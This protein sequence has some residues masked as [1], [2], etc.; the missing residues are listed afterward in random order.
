MERIHIVAATND[1]YA[2]HL[3]VMLTSLFENKKSK[4][5]VTIH[6]IDG[7]L[8][9]D[10]KRRLKNSVKRFQAEIRFLKVDKSLYEAVKVRY[11]LSKETYYRI[12][13]PALLGQ[14]INKAVY[15]DCDLI[16]KED[17]ANLWNISVHDFE[18]GAVQIPGHVDRYKELSI[19]E[20]MG[21][22]NAGVLLLNLRKWRA[23]HTSDKVL[24]YIRD[25]QKKL[26]Y[27]DQDALNAVLKGKW[28][29]LDRRWN[30]QVHRHRHQNFKP[31][32]IHYTAT[33]K[34]WSG[35]P[36]FKEEYVHY[37]RKTIW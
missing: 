34:P 10:K 30:Y 13:I 3:A 36:R 37:L 24:R 4:N 28:K 17:I 25:N 15:L 27:M 33:V 26:K 21:Y 32:I 22:F 8:S 14:H 11:H 1:S 2:K 29:K 7:E 18:L 23:N 12:S 35:N 6:V 20:H 31:A 9:D 16:V 5:P 19:P